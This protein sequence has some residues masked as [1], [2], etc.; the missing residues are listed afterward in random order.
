MGGPGIQAGGGESLGRDAPPRPAAGRRSP[1]AFLLAALLLALV[2]AVLLARTAWDKSDTADETRYVSSAASLWSARTYRDLCE[3]PVLPKW[4]FAVAL[5]LAGAPV[6]AAPAGWQAAM[7]QL[8]RG[9][10]P[11]VLRRTF[12]AARTATIAIVV[13]AGLA[14]W[15]AGTRFG[16]RAGLVAQALWCLSPTVLANG[17]LAALDAWSAALVCAV[18]LAA[19]RACERPTLGRA[20]LV[21]VATGALAATKVTALLVVPVGALLAI[22][23]FVRGA[24]AAARLPA[25]RVA[26]L[27]AAAAAGLLATLWVLYGF[28]IG[29]VD[30]NDPCPFLVA[31]A[32]TPSGFWPFPAWIEGALFQL[33]HAREGHANYLFGET[34]TSGWW[35]FYLAALALKVPV[36]VQAMVCLRIAADVAL[37]A[38]GGRSDRRASVGLLAFPAALL[39]ATSAGRHQPNVSFLL[40]AFPLAMLWIAAGADRAERAF[41]GRGKKLF[42]A[43]LAAAAVESLRVHPHHLM[44]YNLWAGGPV[45]GPRYLVQREDWGQDKRRLAAWQREQGVER[46]FYAPYGP[47]AAEW[48]I[49]WDP[50]PCEPT[51]GVYALHAVEVHRPRFALA[52]GCVDWLTV[53]PPDERIGYSIYVYR[54]DRARLARLAAERAGGGAVFWRSAR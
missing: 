36:G 1:A 17:S 8:L 35:W 48:G 18:V 40:P 7:E 44:F 43:L 13:A 10:S 4:G 2:Q 45:G 38:R 32:P 9:R 31:E 28:S 5:R 41:D 27:G 30:A 11:D 46:L 24:D 49:V 3:A 6:D 29:G 15:R 51:E 22:W 39:L 25:R 53:E 16:P 21:G 54:V 14:L 50:V 19:M 33:R 23:W 52:P 42:L 37:A 26:A 47:N 12:F 34:S 20:A